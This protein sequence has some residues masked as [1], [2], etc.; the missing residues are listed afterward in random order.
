[1]P[2]YALTAVITGFYLLNLQPTV[3]EHPLPPL[4]CNVSQPM[5]DYKYHVV[6][7]QTLYEL[8]LVR[9]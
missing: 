1:M 4:N 3:S 2:H 6:L 5:H 9:V 8:H 7:K